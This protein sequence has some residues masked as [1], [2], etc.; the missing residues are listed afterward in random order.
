MP[1]V[2]TGDEKN[3]AKMMN[4]LVGDSE[5]FFTIYQHSIDKRGKEFVARYFDMPVEMVRPG[6]FQ[7][8]KDGPVLVE[9]R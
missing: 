3:D 9:A 1:E 5:D 4:E 7:R 6:L 8:T 2:F